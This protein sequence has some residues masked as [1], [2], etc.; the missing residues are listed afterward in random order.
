MISFGEVVGTIGASIRLVEGV[1]KSIK[2]GIDLNAG[3]LYGRILAAL[4]QI[5]FFED[6]TMGLLRKIAAQEQVAPLDFER[7]SARFFNTSDDVYRAID[8]LVELDL[9][10]HRGLSIRDANDLKQ[11]IAM[12]QGA[13][14][15]IEEFIFDLSQ[16]YPNATPETKQRL[17]GQAQQVVALIE[18]LNS[19]IERV[20]VSLRASWNR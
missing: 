14:I 11:I 19:T 16:E 10:G 1:Y 4:K 7:A 15:Q 20:D 13:R 18:Q 2:I 8:R 6:G 17:A 3:A 5:Y 12:K 9:H